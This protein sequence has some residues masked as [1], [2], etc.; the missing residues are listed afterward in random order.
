M[1]HLTLTFIFALFLISGPEANSEQLKLNAPGRSVLTL[2]DIKLKGSLLKEFREFR[3]RAKFFSAFVVNVAEGQSGQAR[4]YHRLNFAREDAMAICRYN[5]KNPSRCT[6]IAWIVPRDYTREELKNS[7]SQ[8][9][10]SVFRGKYSQGQR[11]G[12]YGAFA[13]NNLFHSGY[14]WRFPTKQEAVTFA[15]LECEGGG[16][17]AKAGA[18]RSARE[19]LNWDKRLAC[20]V[21]HITTP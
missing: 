20:R 18:P 8:N 3:K 13:I 15:L 17:K 2:N 16:V 4:G 19:S 6:E 1:R 11:K 12:T 9:A 5:S 21:V 10:Q 7:M 14:S